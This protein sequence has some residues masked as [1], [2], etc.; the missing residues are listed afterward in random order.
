VSHQ[1]ERKEKNCLNCGTT[2]VG[3]YCHVCGQE[4]VET[5][6]SFWS[7]TRHFVY[8]ILHFDGKFFHTLKYLF[9]RPGFVARQYCEGK[10]NSYLH[11]IRMYLFTSAVFFLIF[12]SIGGNVTVGNTQHPLKREDRMNLANDYRDRIRN[13]SADSSAYKILAILQD[14]GRAVMADDVFAMDSKSLVTMGNRKYSSMKEYDSVQKTLPADQ[15][16]GWVKRTFAKRLFRFNEKYKK[17]NEG[18]KIFL[19]SLLHK[20]PYILFVSLPFF[21]LILRLLY[22]RRKNFYYSDHAIFTIYHYVFS[23]ILLLLVM[24]VSK[25]EAWTKVSDFDWII[26]LMLLG[27][28]VYLYIEL[29]KFYRQ[30]WLKTFFKFLILNFLGSVLVFVLFMAFL[31][32]SIFEL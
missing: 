9:K 18:L 17:P 7:L 3:R 10:R 19:E 20:L 1:P 8:D 24:G 26:V 14:T 28:A 23:F 4:N 29:R 2:V 25:L 27:W 12:F 16:D 21:A 13:D 11:P 6:E 15:K 5:K 32:F 31:L 30:G 22:I